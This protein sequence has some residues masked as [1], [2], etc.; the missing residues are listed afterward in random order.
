MQ[1]LFL[2]IYLGIFHNADSSTGT[3]TRT[4]TIFSSP[5]SN[6]YQDDIL[7]CLDDYD[8]TVECRGSYTCY[9]TTIYCPTTDNSCLVSCTNLESCYWADIHWVQGNT[10]SLSCS[11]GS[12]YC[13]GVRYPPSSSNDTPLSINCQDYQCKGQIIT[14]PENA[15]CQ[16]ICSG[17]NSCENLIIHCPA[18][19]ICDIFCYGTNSCYYTTVHWSFNPLATSN[20]VCPNEDCNLI[21]PPRNISARVSNGT[22]TRD[23]TLS[24]LSR[25]ASATINCPSEGHCFINCIDEFTCPGS[26]INCPS[27]DDCQVVCS[28]EAA[29]YYSTINGPMNHVLSVFC[30]EGTNACKG[31]TIHAEYSRY[32]YFRVGTSATNAT[33][34]FPSNSRSDVYAISNIYL[35]GND[36]YQ[37]QQ[38][39]AI[40]GF[41]DVNLFF[42]TY[43]VW[44]SH[45]GYMHCGVDY[46]KTC[47]FSSSS[48]TCDSVNTI[49]D[50]P[51]E[52]TQSPSYDPTQSPF[53][54]NLY[55]LNQHNLLHVIAIAMILLLHLLT[56]QF[57]H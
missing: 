36:G 13:I 54:R 39:Y 1:L 31:L 43:G 19:S 16:L 20:L 23:C 22:S 9:N 48:F 10:N 24:A 57:C 34:Y 56:S 12:S 50:N 41:Q 53:P 40:N 49:C 46:D 6:G 11:T 37:S 4:G 2:T 55:P 8:C 3:L 33:I 14:C 38:W 25:C 44:S 17:T 51:L 47:K 26:I 35:D 7:Q 27:N 42:N 30:N 32:F 21:M 29:C 45:G 52:M 18:T 15:K 28:G 5:N